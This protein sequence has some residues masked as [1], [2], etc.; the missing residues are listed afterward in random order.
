MDDIIE[1]LEKEHGQDPETLR[2][3]HRGKTQ[4]YLGMKIHY[5]TKGKSAFTIFDYIQDVLDESP[6]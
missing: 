3:V 1:L 4:N 5:N 6:D 2:T